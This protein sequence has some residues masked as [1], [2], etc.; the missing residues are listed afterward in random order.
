[1]KC[2]FSTMLEAEIFSKS[3]WIET[4]MNGG[5]WSDRTL[6]LT[7]SRL[8]GCVRS[9]AAAVR[10]GSLG[11]CTSASGQ[12]PEG[13]RTRRIDWTRWRV[14][15]RLTGHVWSCLDAYWNR[16]DAGSMVSDQFKQCVRSRGQQRESV[17]TGRLGAS[18]HF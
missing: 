18:D 15:S 7:R 3:S 5:H 1:V 2:L 17:V 12:A 16:P 4:E 8:T 6:N 14:R 11:F 10:C 9:V 13:Q